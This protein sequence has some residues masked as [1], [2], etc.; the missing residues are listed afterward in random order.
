MQCHFQMV[1]CRVH[2]LCLYKQ[3]FLLLGP[4]ILE[5]LIK[6][7]YI[8]FTLILKDQVM[9]LKPISDLDLTIGRKCLTDFLPIVF[10]QPIQLYENFQIIIRQFEPLLRILLGP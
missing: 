7:R 5:D 8:T 3:L 4:H 1:L 6:S 2:L 10:M 9:V